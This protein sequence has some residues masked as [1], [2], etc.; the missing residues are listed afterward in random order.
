MAGRNIQP[1]KK[2]PPGLISSDTLL[3]DTE[4]KALVDTRPL[5]LTRMEVDLLGPRGYISVSG[6]HG[7]RRVSS[8][9]HS[10][11]IPQL[12][13]FSPEVMHGK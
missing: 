4:P 9:M 7:S 13:L 11:H 2:R 12:L 8:L 10:K 3:G 5:T 1:V 6:E